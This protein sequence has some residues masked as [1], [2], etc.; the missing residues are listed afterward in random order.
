MLDG[1]AEE[2]PLGAE[3]GIGP[4]R[5]ETAEVLVGHRDGRL[6]V[7]PLGHV[8]L[9]RDRTIAAAELLGQLLELVDRARRED[10]APAVGRERPRRRGAD[11]GRRTGEEEDP[12]VAAHAP[13][14]SAAAHEE[15]R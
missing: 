15:R 4:R 12:V 3:A 11:A 5:V 10:E 1:V 14:S 2:A 8:A 13:D 7:G 6:L 9:D